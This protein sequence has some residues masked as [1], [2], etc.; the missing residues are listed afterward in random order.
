M[1]TLPT[2]G[3]T[4]AEIQLPIEGMTY[5]SCVNRIERFLRKTE[6]VQPPD[7]RP[8]AAQRRPD[9]PRLVDRGV[10]NVDANARPGQTQRIRFRIDQPGTYVVECTVEGH[11][12][13]GMVGTLLVEVAD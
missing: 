4:G 13:A 10:A 6:G 1:K 12:E 8:R 7:G 2:Q 5:A 3:P 9:V 11:A